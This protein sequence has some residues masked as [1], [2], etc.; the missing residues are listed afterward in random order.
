MV[1]VD[2]SVWIDYF[3]NGITADVLDN[4][5]DCGDLCINDLILAELLPSARHRKEND[6]A[7]LLCAVPKLQMHI[8]WDEIILM[9]T[10]NLSHGIN[11]V[12]IPDLMIAQNALQNNVRLFSCDKHFLLMSSLFPIQLLNAT[13]S[14]AH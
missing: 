12:G 10:T 11:N 14:T 8:D 5:I 13:D 1:L 9:Q 3:R 7:A 4:L 6:L 2:T